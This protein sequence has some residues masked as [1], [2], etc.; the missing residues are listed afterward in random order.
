MTHLAAVCPH[1]SP[2]DTP[3]LECAADVERGS[4]GLHGPVVCSR[5]GQIVTLGPHVCYMTV[6][7]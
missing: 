5:C 4:I 7:T 3:C 2:V 1:G 6:L